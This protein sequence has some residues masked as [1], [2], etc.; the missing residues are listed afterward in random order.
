MEA[1]RD[2][3]RVAVKSCHSAGKSFTAAE[4]VA[5]W[6][7]SHEPGE[8]FVVTSAPTGAQVKAILWREIGRAHKRG[9]LPGRTNLTEWYDDSGELVAFGRKP[10]DYEPTAFQGIHAR[11]VLVI[12]DEACGIP[13]E[14]WDAADSLASNVGGRILAIGN[15]DD[16]Q[17]HFATVCDL[18]TWHVIRISA[19]DTP[20]FTDEEV[21]PI[22]LEM[23]VS[24]EWVEAKAIEWGESSPLFTSKVLGLFPTDAEDGV[25]PMSWATQCR[26]LELLEGGDFEVG[27]DV[28]AGGKDR[29]VCWVRQ[30]KKAIRKFTWRGVTDPLVLATHV[31]EEVI[32]EY[33][34]V[35]LKVDSI[36][37]GW[38]IGGIIDGWHRDGRH[39]CVVCPVN[40]SERA[41]DDKHFLNLRA[42]VWWMARENSRLHL[43][44]LGA[45]E[46]DDV[47][48]LTAVKYHTL[49][50]RSRIQVEKKA[51]VIKRI[52]KSPDSA[53]A[54]ILAFHTPVWEATFFAGDVLTARIK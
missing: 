48:E 30:G 41:D 44:D 50:P 15:P 12:L 16:P 4:V 52:K 27:L 33:E 5:W 19:Y 43:W 49:N 32:H 21:P 54:L 47:D 6:L 25:V 10:N 29:T 9:D 53:D 24:K 34:P 23:L 31:L 46:D 28:S 22:L 8:A 14:L 40:V 3:S 37:V 7:D 13:K 11:F 38:G 51:E 2:K 35:A 39:N 36:G 42:E 26:T 1:V 18:P 20:A 45:L 17:S